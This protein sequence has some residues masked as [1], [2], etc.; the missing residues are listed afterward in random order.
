M[1]LPYEISIVIP[2]L[3]DD[4][5]LAALL[6][7]IRS[8]PR[9]PREI[10]VVDGDTRASTRALCERQ[11]AVWLPS[12]H[13]RGVQLMKGAAHAHGSTLW[14]LRADCEP[15]PDSLTAISIAIDSGAVG[16]YFRFRF[17][18]QR[19][20]FK[21]LLEAAIRWRCRLGVPYGD[22]GLFAERESFDVC[23]GFAPTPLFEEVPLVKALRRQGR[24]EALSV[25]IGVSERRWQRDG[26]LRRALSNRLLA[27]GY[28]A[29]LSPARLA[30]W[31]GA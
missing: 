31:L 19:R 16:G 6:Q 1:T 12:V 10:I 2:T 8:W 25:P 28:M 27:L 11:Q 18:G 29:G 30:R 15:H 9:R 13:G 23:G 4:A 17:T 14:F 7:R 21:T 5:A 3:A 20:W 26:W 22:Q 24:F